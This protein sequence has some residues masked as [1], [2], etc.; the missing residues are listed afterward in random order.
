MT[1][2]TMPRIPFTLRID[3]RLIDGFNEA[4]KKAGLSRNV[5]MEQLLLGHLK[6]V[7]EIPIDT[8]PLGEKRGGPREGSGKPK[9]SPNDPPAV[10]NHLSKVGAGSSEARSPADV[11]A[12]G[13]EGE[14]ERQSSTR[15]EG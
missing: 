8:Q 3:D 13:G 2:Q 5:Y 10:E 9:R 15:R 1:A 14:G 11:D 6:V 4:A 7:G 12:I